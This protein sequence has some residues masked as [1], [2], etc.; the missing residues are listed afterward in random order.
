MSSHLKKKRE[1]ERNPLLWKLLLIKLTLKVP[2]SPNPYD[3]GV[4]KTTCPSVQSPIF[5]YCF[6]CPFTSPSQ[7]SL[8]SSFS[9]PWTLIK[10][11]YQKAKGKLNFC[12]SKSL[13]RVSGFELTLPGIQQTSSDGSFRNILFLQ[14]KGH[15]VF[16]LQYVSLLHITSH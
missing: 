10:S 7:F 15:H 13:P 12:F 3:L 9:N 5:L 11:R 14:N 16:S 6:L 2:W 4:S 8:K 1:K